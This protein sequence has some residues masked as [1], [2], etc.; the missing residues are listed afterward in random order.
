MAK[1]ISAATRKKKNDTQRARRAAKKAAEASAPVQTAPDP[2]GSLKASPI[3]VT[4]APAVDPRLPTKYTDAWIEQN[5]AELE[6][7][8]LLSPVKISM[9]T[10]EDRDPSKTP[11]HPLETSGDYDNTIEA[12]Q[13]VIDENLEPWQS[14]DPMREQAEQHIKPGMRPHYLSPRT[15]DK[16]G[17]RGWETVL[18]DA[19]KQIKIGDLFLGQM[20]E[21]KALQ[22]KEHYRR[23]TAD[24]LT[25]VHENQQENIE[26]LV[27]E[28]HK[29]GLAVI[30]AG[31]T[32][33]DRATNQQVPVGLS[34]TRGAAPSGVVSE[35]PA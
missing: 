26:R 13:A 21:R 4:T 10:S 27:K 2:Q 35:R 25:S 24:D 9:R 1:T 19:G 22:R 34:I 28:A 17:M 16:R 29:H 6:E 18:T 5:R 7:R 12:R 15:V 14:P 30:P 23:K 32:V 3:G 33:T 11:Y 31:E 8:G 20:P